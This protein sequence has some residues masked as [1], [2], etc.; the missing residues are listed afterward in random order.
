VSLFGHLHSPLLSGRIVTT[1]SNTCWPVAV[2]DLDGTVVNTIPLIIASYEHAVTSVL[3]FCPDPVEARNWIGQ[4]LGETFYQRYPEN[5][6]EL[7]AS[8]VAWNAANLERLV[9]EYPGV[10]ALLSD[11]AL[12]GVKL[13]VATSK[14]R[15][16]A[17]NT[18][19]CAG[20]RN[21]LGVTVAMEDTDFHKPDPRPLLL[22]LE[23]IGASADDAVYIGDAVVDVRAALAAGMDVIAVTWGAGE[24]ADLVAAGPTAVVDSVAELRS[25]LLG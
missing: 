7:V 15:V 2:F 3:G 17:E 16:S 11:L 25:L 10:D 9:Q 20:L 22:A 23:R 14:R 1:V 19:K 24:R 12:A 21:R 18:L 4:T 8:Y 6:A 13:G 5:G